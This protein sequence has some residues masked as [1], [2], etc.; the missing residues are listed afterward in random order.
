MKIGSFGGD[1]TVG[2]GPEGDT[3]IHPSD[4]KAHIKHGQ[5]ITSSGLYSS[6]ILVPKP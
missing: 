4:P 5:T 2:N 1:T 3:V 6:I